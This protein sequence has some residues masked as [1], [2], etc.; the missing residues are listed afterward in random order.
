MVYTVQR[1]CPLSSPRY[2]SQPS[3]NL[4]V[5]RDPKKLRA[6][7]ETTLKVPASAI[8]TYLTIIPGDGK[9]EV[10]VS[11]TLRNPLDQT[12]LVDTI[13]FGIGT[14]P[15]YRASLTAPITMADKTVCED[16]TRTI[17][18]SLSSL[19]AQGIESTAAGTKPLYITVS[20]TGISNK[21]RDVPAALWPLY[22]WTLA[23]PHDDKK[24]MEALVLANRG[25]YLR[26]C[27][28][29]R[30][31]LLMNGAPKGL[32]KIRVGWE[33]AAQESERSG[34]KEPGPALGYSISR[35]DVGLFI[36]RRVMVEGGWEGRC[37]SLT[38]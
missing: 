4:P 30:P 17:F 6:N 23:V 11:T 12:K 26:D 22:H 13:L 25:R 28:I 21:Q 38:N 29:V 36:Y 32:D 16:C 9:N 37:V 19:A 10:A 15:K 14:V 1:V 24:K 8:D 27:V 31:T 35:S 7:L 3:N 34:L 20:T 2:N 18:A 33:W 5:A